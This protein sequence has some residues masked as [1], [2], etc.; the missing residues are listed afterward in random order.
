MKR[1]SSDKMSNGFWEFSLSVYAAPGVSDECLELQDRFGIDV[2]LLLFAAYAGSRHLIL[3]PE[4]IDRCSLLVR[5]WREQVIQPLRSVR[6]VTKELLQQH[7]PQIQR[8]AEDIGSKVKLIELDSEKVQQDLLYQWLE[9]QTL[10]RTTDT[11]Q[12]IRN[13]VETILRRSLSTQQSASSPKLISA[14]FIQGQ[15]S[16]E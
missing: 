7:S 9:G 6:R 13:N 3:S 10:D 4:S 5:Q 2:N 16:A 11:D 15:G 1:R 14:A 8:Q 12:A